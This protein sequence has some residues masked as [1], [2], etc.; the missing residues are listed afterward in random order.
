VPG[1]YVPPC[2]VAYIYA[3]RGEVDTAIAWLERAFEEA[4]THL[5]GLSIIRAYDPLRG[6]PRFASLLGRLRH[7][8]PPPASAIGAV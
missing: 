5:N 7:E 1:R 3:A 8:P 4:D 6:D 2:H